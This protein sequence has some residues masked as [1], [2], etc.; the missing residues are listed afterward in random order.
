MSGLSAAQAGM[1][2]TSNNVA[3]VGT[4]GYAR[5]KVSTSTNVV[6]G[7]T[8]G[9]VAGAPERVADRFLEAT[10]YRRAGDTGRTGV[11]AS[12]LDRLQ[13]LLG[14]PGSDSA[15]PARL[16]RV[17]SSAIA[18]S[19]TASSTQAP[20]VF[21]GSVTD[22][23]TAVQ[24][25][26]SDV[27]S[28]RADTATEVGD[29][30]SRINT[31]LSDIHSLNNTIAEQTASGRGSA[32]AT[33][34]RMSAL[35]ELGGLIGVSIYDQPDGR[36]TIDA[37][38]GTVLLDRRLRQLSA[39]AAAD[40]SQTTFEP[41]TVRFADGSASATGD[42]IDTAQVGGKLGGLI[43]L[44]DNLLPGF[45]QKLGVLT[46]AL[47]QTLNAASNASTAVPAPNTLTGRPNGT[48]GSDRLGFTGAAI[49]A[50][51]DSAGKVVARTSVDFS[52]LGSGATIDDAVAAI[53]AGL[54]GAGTASF[55]GG[56]LTIT[57]TAPANGVVVAQDPASPSDRGGVGFSQYFGLND[58]VRSPTSALVPSG[59]IASDPLGFST[60]QSATFELRDATGRLLGAQTIAP[61]S[62]ASFGDV[63]SE[64]NGG[65][66]A[67]FGSFSLD[68]Q[69]RI[70][71]QPAGG[72]VSGAT[73]AVTSDNTDRFGTGMSLSALTGLSNHATGPAG[74]SVRGDLATSPSKLPLAQF[75]TAAAVGQ[76]A[77]GAGDRRGAATFVDRLSAALDLGNDG[78]A[79]VSQFVSNLVSE[80]GAKAARSQ[81]SAGS[82]S[83]RLS[84]AVNRRNSYSGVSIDEELAQMVVLQN[85]Y[86]AA[87]RMVSAANDMYDTLLRMMG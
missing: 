70:A 50:V 86:S 59:F 25:L 56:A 34:R 38:D 1:S 68:D 20:A 44:R 12:Y 24:Q 33:T 58:L 87:A 74:V 18:M 78:V 83:A 71:F 37:A 17:V 52:A 13:T 40:P 15:L 21:I 67:T 6:G 54:G 79:T 66:L 10:V 57:A 62:G 28:L 19:G 45:N 3:N 14:T 46:D 53:N 65:A 7:R 22:A 82:A 11:T 8:V 30:V 27:A 51:T 42:T 35:E 73:L 55:S 5:E 81:D 47:A 49:F 41:V 85:S 72:A 60:G 39:P 61:A 77:M 36:V 2:T 32:A 23:I 4:P 16:D 29:T 9:V 31:L 43:D 84:D 69:G 26:G 64:L 76:V 75:D 48:V 63:I 80:T